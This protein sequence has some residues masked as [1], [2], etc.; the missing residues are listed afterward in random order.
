MALNRTNTSVEI[1]RE[2]DDLLAAVQRS[3]GECPRHNCPD[4]AQHEHP[5]DKQPWLADVT[6]GFRGCELVSERVYQF[7]NTRSGPDGIGNDWRICKSRTQ[8]SFADLIGG[9]IDSAQVAL[10]EGNYSAL[11]TEVSKDLQMLF[12]LRHPAVISGNDEQC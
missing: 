7:L 6:L 8:E 3:A 5:I 1:A 9:N 4:A 12:A 10:R 2:N 11:H